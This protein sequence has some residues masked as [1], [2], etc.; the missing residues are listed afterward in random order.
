VQRTPRVQHTPRCSGT[1][2]DYPNCPDTL[3]YDQQQ[4]QIRSTSDDVTVQ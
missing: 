3:I 2:W 4:M 1:A